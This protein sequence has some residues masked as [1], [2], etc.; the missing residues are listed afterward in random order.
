VSN[1]FIIESKD[2]QTSEIYTQLESAIKDNIILSGIDGDYEY[3]LT[4]SMKAA[5]KVI[6][7]LITQRENAAR[8]DELKHVSSFSS[9]YPNPPFSH[10]ATVEERIA[11]LSPKP[12]DAEKPH[13]HDSFCLNYGKC[14]Q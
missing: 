11:E 5:M 8:I 10:L 14:S 2:F 6:N 4:L 7:T 9:W 13:V 3:D 1:M 12:L